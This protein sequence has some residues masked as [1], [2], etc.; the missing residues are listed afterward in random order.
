MKPP[1]LAIVYRDPSD[2]PNTSHK[3]LGICAINTSK[4]LNKFGVESEVWGV[5]SDKEIAGHL[6]S[7]PDI[8]HCLIQAP[9]AATD[10]LIR[11]ANRFKPV[12]FA[13]N[14]H[15]NIGYLQSDT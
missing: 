13:V 15:S 4:T 5:Y 8:T 7:R 2:T 6:S 14:C 12:K 11:L 10:K 3:G 9:W 1:K